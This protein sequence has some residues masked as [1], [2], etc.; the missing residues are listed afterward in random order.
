MV[1]ELSDLSIRAINK[2]TGPQNN[3]HI[4]EQA[5]DFWF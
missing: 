2:S 3:S 5:V 4:L 1:N